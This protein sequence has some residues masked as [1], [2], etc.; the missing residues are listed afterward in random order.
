MQAQTKGITIDRL[1]ERGVERDGGQPCQKR[2]RAIID[3]TNTEPVAKASLGKLLRAYRAT[4]WS[5][6]GLSRTLTYRVGLN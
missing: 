2:D 5:T 3:Q 6:H 1:E 4:E